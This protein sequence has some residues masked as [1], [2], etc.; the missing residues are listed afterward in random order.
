MRAPLYSAAAALLLVAQAAQA[1]D[2]MLD[3]SLRFTLKRGSHALSLRTIATPD[4]PARARMARLTPVAANDRAHALDIVFQRQRQRLSRTAPPLG[5][6]LHQFDSRSRTLLMKV[7]DR[8]PLGDRM[9]VTAGLQGI[10]SINRG[11]NVTTVGTRDR[12]GARDW[13]LPRMTLTFRP[14]TDAALRLTYRETLHGFG[15]SGQIGPMGLAHE[16][17]RALARSLRPETHRLLQMDADWSPVPDTM[18]AAAAFQGR[19]NERLAFVDRG[20]QPLNSGSARFQGV[21]LAVEHR[22][23]RHWRGSIQYVAAQVDRS[24]SG[25]AQESS[26]TAESRWSDGPWSATVRGARR[27]RP[28]LAAGGNT[29]HRG[30]RFEGE[31]RYR[32]P[33]APAT[34]AYVA[35]TVVD[36]DMLASTAL[37]RDDSAGPVHAADRA[38]AVMLGMGLHW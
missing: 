31:L 12:V 26:L 15:D 3:Q 24:G 28:A 19:V 13:L 35:L 2:G 6:D 30:V 36:P 25:T 1:Q 38:R 33:G 37:L 5:I 16:S 22:L 7:E 14:D 17:Y 9:M 8:L 32:L 20:Y 29:R 18:L 27:S 34:P 23:S 4:S 11:A 21:R 10:K